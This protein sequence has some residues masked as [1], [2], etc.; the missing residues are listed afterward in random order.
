MNFISKILRFI[1]RE[2][3][4]LICFFRIIKLKLLYPGITID[5]KSK[6]EGYCSIVCI[7]G[8]KLNISNSTISFGTNIVA[9]KGS[10][11]SINNSF[12]GRNCVITSKE[13]ITINSGCLLAE[14]V[15]IRDQDHLTDIGNGENLR[16]EFKTSPI[17][18]EENA[19][20]AA[21]A[22]ILKGVQIG[23]FSVVA[24]SAVVTKNVP[25]F[26]LWGGVPAKLIK[27]INENGH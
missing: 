3:G 10:T 15:V 17:E 25:S 12:I 6:I 21:K 5:F 27:Q 9:D 13:K 16:G 7:K 11:L 22:T 4:Q 1:V 18:I 24:A 20:I 23:R 8:G 14:M 19:W 26:Q 2:T